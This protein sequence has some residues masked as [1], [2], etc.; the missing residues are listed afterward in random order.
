MRRPVRLLHTSDVHL[1]PETAETRDAWEAFEQLIELA[2]REA[3]DVLL[4]AGDLFESS[5]VPDTSLRRIERLLREVPSRVIILPGNHDA[6]DRDSVYHRWPVEEAIPRVTVLRNPSGD[7]LRDVAPGLAVWGR[8]TI[9]HSPNYRPLQGVQPRPADA[10]YYVIVA[11]GHVT[12]PGAVE[13]QSS[14][15]SPEELVSVAS[16][17]VA[18]GHTHLYAPIPVE[19]V[20]AWYSGAPTA[21]GGPGARGHVLL[22]TLTPG[23]PTQVEPISLAAVPR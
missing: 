10:L 6:L 1:G 2:N 19:G 3:A 9:E 12:Y 20:Q 5:R 8:A 11:H 21:G 22:V 23:Q 14:L 15:I 17:Y 16:D 7:L 4:V 18:L 13:R